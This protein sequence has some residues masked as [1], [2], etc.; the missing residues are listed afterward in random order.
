VVLAA[1]LVTIACFALALTVLSAVRNC[2]SIY[3]GSHFDSGGVD[4]F[5]RDWF[6]LAE[7]IVIGLGIAVGAY[8]SRAAYSRHSS[9][10]ALSGSA[11]SR[12]RSSSR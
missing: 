12:S 10:G 4:A 3:C 7:T 5:G 1:L 11:C 6:T 2:V 8:L 9:D